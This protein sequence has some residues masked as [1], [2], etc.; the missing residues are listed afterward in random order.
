MQSGPSSFR[1]LLSDQANSCS[2]VTVNGSK[3]LDLTFPAD[4]VKVGSFT[5][6]DAVQRSAV[7]GEAE[8]DYFAP[9]ADGTCKDD[10]SA[11][12]TTGTVTLTRAD[13]RVVG[14]YDITFA[15]GRLSGSFDTEAC[16]P[17]TQ[18]AKSD[19]KE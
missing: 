12:A 15:D 19:C 1:I 18:F 4:V 3:N 13:T 17:N 14:T 10:F 9:K 5:V 16:A 2:S 11:T 8:A 6:I 7:A